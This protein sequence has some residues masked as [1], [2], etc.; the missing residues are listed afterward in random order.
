MLDEGANGIV[1]VP[2]DA[3]AVE[4][5]E[6]LLES[7]A[8]LDELGEAWQDC[9]GIHVPHPAAARYGQAKGERV[10]RTLVLRDRRIEVP[11]R[12]APVVEAVAAPLDHLAIDGGRV[13]VRLDQLD[14]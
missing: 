2:A 7:T 10:A 8:E 1:A 5:P 13:V 11:R 4:A 14:V 9:R 3:R 6:H 12:H